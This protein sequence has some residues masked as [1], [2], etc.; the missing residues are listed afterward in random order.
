MTAG[1]TAS[2]SDLG[3]AR[4][5]TRYGYLE[6][7][8]MGREGETHGEVRFSGVRVGSLRMMAKREPAG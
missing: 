7:K 5:E 1:S 8:V 4:F 6:G 2:R 3:S